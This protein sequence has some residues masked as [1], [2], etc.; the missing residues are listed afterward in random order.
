MLFL[1]AIVVIS[2]AIGLLTY[3]KKDLPGA[4]LSAIDKIILPLGRLLLVVLLLCVVLNISGAIRV[5]PTNE[6]TTTPESTIVETARWAALSGHIYPALNSSPYTAAPY[7]PLFYLGLE[8]IGKAA[9][10]NPHRIRMLLRFLVFASY[11]LVGLLAYALTRSAGASREAGLLAC[12]AALASPYVLYWNVSARPDFP[13]LLLSLLAVWVVAR[14]ESPKTGEMILAGVLCA[15]AMLIKQSFVAAPLAIALSFLRSYRRLAVF[16]AAGTATGL[17]VIGYLLLRGAPVLQE[18]LLIGH[19]PIAIKPAIELLYFYLA[20]GLGVVVLLGGCAG[21]IR[22]LGSGRWPL[23]LLGRYFI[24]ALAVALVTLPQVGS[25]DNYLFEVWSIASILLACSIPEFEL[26]WR[27]MGQ[28]LRIGATAALILLTAQSVHAIRHP[29]PRL[30]HYRFEDLRGLHIFS[31]NPN[32]TIA[33]KDPEFLSTFL[34]TILDQRGSWSPA[35]VVNE[36]HRQEF[37]VVFLNLM[38]HKVSNWNGQLTL[39][40][41]II[42][43]TDMS[44]RPLCATSWLLVMVPKTRPVAFSRSEASYTLHTS[45]YEVPENYAPGP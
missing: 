33:G 9:Q 31:T 43:A 24:L 10:G 44:Y 39:A 42:R 18:T 13:A 8:G 38:G 3:W 4:Y 26:V 22:A 6:D 16:V 11:L 7:G 25:D 21:A 19:S 35:G 23:T 45:C 17:S 2:L 1:T 41:A 32:L 37:D 5:F 15:A 28:P 40:P 27:K 30:R 12:T 36:I 20:L 14:R 34:T 29:H